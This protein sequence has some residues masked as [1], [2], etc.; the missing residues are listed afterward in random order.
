LRER[1]VA[2]PDVTLRVAN[3]VWV[4]TGQGPR[5]GFAALVRSGFAGQVAAV[6]FAAPASVTAINAWVREATSGAIPELVDQLDPATEFVIANAVYFK[7][8]WATAFDPA[9]TQQRPFRLAGGRQRNAAMMQGRFALGYADAG[10]M[11]AVMLP[12]QGDRLAMIVATPKEPGQLQPFL[13]EGAQR[14]WSAVLAALP[15]A[16]RQVDLALPRFRATFAADL[17]GTLRG[18]GLAPAL[19]PGAD[20]GGMLQQSGAPG[21]VIHRVVLEVTEEGAEA[22]AAT[23]IVGMRAAIPQRAVAFHADRPFVVAIV[24]RA[25]QTILFLGYVAEP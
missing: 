22:A 21:A 24:D 9:R 11:H 18:L 4:R 1:L 3:A 16:E 2:A 12:Y 13:R 17:I 14:G 8:S 23:G 6:D 7:G 5:E 19:T 10:R 25:T 20:Y 15:F